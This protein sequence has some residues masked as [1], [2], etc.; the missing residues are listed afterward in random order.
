M[1]LI[2][3]PGIGKTSICKVLSTAL[4]M[5]LVFIPLGSLDHN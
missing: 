1:L 5:P 3:P 2:G 4:E